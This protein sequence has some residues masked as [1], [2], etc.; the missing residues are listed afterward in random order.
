MFRMLS[1]RYK[2]SWSDSR[3][4]G[5]RSKVMRECWFERRWRGKQ[6][7]GPAECESAKQSRRLSYMKNTHLWLQWYTVHIP[8]LTT[9]EVSC[10]SGWCHVMRVSRSLKHVYVFELQLWTANIKY[11]THV[12]F[13]KISKLK[14]CQLEC[15]PMLQWARVLE[16]DRRLC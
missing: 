11:N 3:Q 15:L 8:T 13:L 10:G 5:E 4:P 2:S 12:E 14:W 9:C 16:L 6:I 7:V 1:F